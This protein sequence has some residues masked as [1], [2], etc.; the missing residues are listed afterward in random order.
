MHEALTQVTAQGV[1]E[2]FIMVMLY[3]NYLYSEHSSAHMDQNGNGK[4][5]IQKLRILI[6]EKILRDKITKEIYLK[7]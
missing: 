4:N 5:T 2:T 3:H 6:K 7:L 1:Y